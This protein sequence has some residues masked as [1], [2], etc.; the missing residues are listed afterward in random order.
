MLVI[1]YVIYIDRRLQ[2]YLGD[3]RAPALRT[4]PGN[5]II[6]EISTKLSK[7]LHHKISIHCQLV[8]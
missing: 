7:L 6:T 5:N 4:G 3:T 8:I 1:T 2:A